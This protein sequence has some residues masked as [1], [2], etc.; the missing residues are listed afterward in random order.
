MSVPSAASASWAET[1]APEPPE[2]AIPRFVTWVEALPGM[3]VFVAHP[4]TWDFGFVYWYL[5]RFCG[6]SPFGHSALDM[7]TL[8]MALLKLPFRDCSKRNFPAAW[9]SDV[10]AHTHVAL[11]D[12][13]EQAHILAAMLRDLDAR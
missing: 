1:A 9:R 13:R 8:A 3:P 7:K 5:I 12:A 6:H 2:L 11:D 4:A 10:H